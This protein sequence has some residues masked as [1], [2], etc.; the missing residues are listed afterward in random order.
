M[1]AVSPSSP[2]LASEMSHTLNSHAHLI[3]RATESPALA[4]S[5]PTRVPRWSTLIHPFASYAINYRVAPSLSVGKLFVLAVYLGVIFYAAFYKSNPFTDPARAGF[6]AMSQIPIVI[7][8]ANKNNLLSYLC[9]VAYEKVRMVIYNTHR[10][11][12][13]MLV[14]CQ[15]S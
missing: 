2:E 6:I 11:C 13:L 14:A 8:L 1:H 9:G 5:P 7:G 3:I 4:H 15:L 10:V 12:L